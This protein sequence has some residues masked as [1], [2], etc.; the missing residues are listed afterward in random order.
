MRISLMFS[1]MPCCLA[2]TQFNFYSLK[3][4]RVFDIMI[5]KCNYFI[6]NFQVSKAYFGFNDWYR[7][8]NVGISRLQI[9][10]I[11][12]IFGF[13]PASLFF[14]DP[15]NSCI[16]RNQNFPALRQILR[17]RALFWLYRQFARAYIYRVYRSG[18]WNYF[19]DFRFAW[20]FRAAFLQS[21]HKPDKNAYNKNNK[22]C[23]INPDFFIFLHFQP[24]YR[25]NLFIMAM[26]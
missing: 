17:S 25:A 11:V 26:K 13:K 24:P 18:N 22:N 1:C 4:P 16:L 21:K 6:P 14:L 5:C 2:A 12:L 7:G 20:A 23:K 10:E 3:R 8:I 15:D 9:V 19:L